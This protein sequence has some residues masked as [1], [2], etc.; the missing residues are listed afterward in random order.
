MTFCSQNENEIKQSTCSRRQNIYRRKEGVCWIRNLFLFLFLKRIG[1]KI[2]ERWNKLG[3][4]E[5]FPLN[6]IYN[7]QIKCLSFLKENPK[8]STFWAVHSAELRA[9]RRWVYR[10]AP[11]P[12][13]ALCVTAPGRSWTSLT[14]AV[15]SPINKTYFSLA[16][17]SDGTLLLLPLAYML[18][19]SSDC[20]APVNPS[21][22]PWAQPRHHG[23]TSSVVS[24][25]MSCCSGPPVLHGYRQWV[26]AVCPRPLSE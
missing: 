3:K 7:R 25:W 15:S 2:L 19:E 21:Q 13:A 4:T 5:P 8:Q 22:P 14:A 20:H 9:P 23:D 17:L 1:I 26:T 6:N 10:L 12:P 24:H 16:W 11:S 18:A